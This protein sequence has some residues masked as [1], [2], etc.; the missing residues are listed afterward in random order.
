[1]RRVVLIEVRRGAAPLAVLVV[2]VTTLG[3]LFNEVE[4]WVGRWTG[5]NG[6]IRTVLIV[7]GPIAVCLAAWQGGRER[8][9]R[10]DELLA[11]TPRSAAARVV[12]GWGATTAGVAAGVVVAWLVAAVL[13]VRVATYSGGPA[14]VTLAVGFIGVAAFTAAGYT[15][16]RLVPFRVVAPVAGLLAYVLVAT[17]TYTQKGMQWL[18]PSTDQLDSGHYLLGW[19]ALAQT[20]FFV[21]VA[22]TALVIVSARFK[23]WA[24]VPAALATAV[25]Y[26]LASADSDDVVVDDA[27]ALE[28][29]CR[30]GE[31]TVCAERDLAFTLGDLQPWAAEALG[32]WDGLSN[33][34][35]RVVFTR[36]DG[37]DLAGDGAAVISPQSYLGWDGRLNR[38]GRHDADLVLEI[39]RATVPTLWHCDQEATLSGGLT[40]EDIDGVY[41]TAVMLVGGDPY[42]SMSFGNHGQ[43]PPPEFASPVWGRVSQLS[44][45]EQ[46]A[47]FTAYRSVVDGCDRDVLAELAGRAS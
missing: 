18:V 26:L 23:A 45:A 42:H 7:V 20:V 11:S 31:V 37:G 17:M 3:L 19:A 15:V 35:T 24:L 27:A 2:A 10:I 36:F 22:A 34:P 33:P 1:M 47:W 12:L 28:W 14:W 13:V 44:R 40:W 16:G 9:R 4:W 25:A 46:D 43:V 5:L 21:A 8:R 38:H 32:T 30:D 39:R 41:G 6:W 29:V